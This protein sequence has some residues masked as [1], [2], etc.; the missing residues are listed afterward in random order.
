[1]SHYRRA[2]AQG[3]TYFFTVV[4][5]RRQQILCEAPLRT[6]LSGAIKDVQ[7]RHPFIIDAWV[8]LPDHLH[9][10]W[11]LP[12]GDADFALRWSLIKRKVSV[13]CAEHYKRLEWLTA[14]KKNTVNRRCGN[15][16]IGN[17]KS[18]MREILTVMR[19]TSITIR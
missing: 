12:Q 6:A 10:L 19:I 3:A 16:V 8:L 2:D 5:Y 15:A 18:G 17:I 7:T 14:S 9:C 1:M 13:V 11:T 4:T